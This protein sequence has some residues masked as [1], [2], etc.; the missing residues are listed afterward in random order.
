LPVPTP[1]KSAGVSEGVRRNAP[2]RSRRRR[3]PATRKSQQPDDDEDENASSRKQDEQDQ[4]SA[5]RKKERQPADQHARTSVVE[6]HD[7]R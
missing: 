5:I 6:D 2:L 3:K 7:V 4:L 1:R